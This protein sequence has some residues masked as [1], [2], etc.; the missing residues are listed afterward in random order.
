MLL[1]TDSTILR[2]IVVY[3]DPLGPQGAFIPGEIRDPETTIFEEHVFI[4]GLHLEQT[5]PPAW[6]TPSSVTTGI[7]KCP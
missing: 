7:L 2:K 1:H 3:L 5:K 6:I 4:I